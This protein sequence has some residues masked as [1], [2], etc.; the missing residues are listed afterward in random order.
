[1]V[2]LNNCSCNTVCNPPLPGIAPATG[3]GGGG[4]IPLP[5][6]LP[7]PMSGET[8]IGTAP[9]GWTLMFLTMNP[10]GD[11]A[12]PASVFAIS[13]PKARNVIV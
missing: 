9:A 4:G 11:E 13:G 5:L 6:P 8:S 2:T 1:M 10:Y 12:K 7:P 3:A